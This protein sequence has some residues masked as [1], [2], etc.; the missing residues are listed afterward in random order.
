M[1]KRILVVDD[2]YNIRSVLQEVLEEEAY[3]VDTASDG[4][5]AWNKLTLQPGKYDVILLDI[6]M[7][8]L[9]GLQLIQELQNQQKETSLSVVVLSS[10]EEAIQQALHMGVCHALKKPFDLE[11]ILALISNMCHCWQAFPA[12]S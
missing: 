5:I 11:A 9:N 1:N 4:F 10:D 6:H 3:E 12:V 7:P 2:D 8:R